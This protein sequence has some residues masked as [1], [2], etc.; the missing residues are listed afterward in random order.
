MLG[1]LL[2]CT[3]EAP[4][5]IISLPGGKK[6]KVYRG[7]GSLEAMVANQ[8]SRA[9]YGQTGSSGEKLVP[10]GVSGR[11]PIKG[12]VA[13]VLYQLLGGLRSGMGNVGE[14][15]I[16]GLQARGDFTRITPAGVTESHPHDL[17]QFDSAPNYET[18]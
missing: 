13:S 5:D 12:D 1:K 17:A 11:I 16:L 15:T 8:E 14:K 2:A 9:R 10:E 3:V 18:K 7:M 6:L 4:G